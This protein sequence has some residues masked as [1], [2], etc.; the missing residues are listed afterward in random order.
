M[1]AGSTYSTIATT[2]LG[3]AQATIS[4]N[5]FSGYTDLVCIYSA[6]NTS[7]S[8]QDVYVQFN[9]DTGSNYSATL[10]WGSGSSAGSYRNSNDAAILLDFYGSAGPTSGPFNTGIVNIMNYSNT[11][12][13]KTVLGRTSRADNGVDAGIGLW[14]NTAAITSMTFRL[15]G[16]GNNFATGSIFTL[17]GISAA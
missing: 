3:S 7:A 6:Q 2:T 4:F 17:Y 15:S 9:G 5:S 11:A 16:S 1:P 10:L 13:F 12:T 8:A 14:R